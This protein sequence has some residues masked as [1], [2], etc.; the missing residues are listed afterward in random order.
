MQTIRLVLIGVGQLGRRFCRLVEAKE[1]LLRES[2]AL[3]LLLVGVADS[4]GAAWSSEGLDWGEV[5]AIKEQD[6]SVADLPTGRT[7]VTGLTLLQQVEAE[8]LLEASPVNLDQGAEPGLSHIRTAL[9]RGM[10]VVTPNKGPLV[11]AWDELHR[12]AEE[13][14]VA[15]RYDGT[16]AGGLPA[17]ALASRDLRGA[18]I[19]R[20]EAV[21]NL[22]TGYVMDCLADGIPYEEALAMAREEGILEADTSWDL[23]GWDAAAKLVILTRSATGYPATLESVHRIGLASVHPQELKMA[24]SQGYLY[25]MLAR[26]VRTSE[27]LYRLSVAPVPLTPEHPLGRLGRREMGVTFDTDIYGLITATIEEATPLPSAATML[28]DLLKIYRG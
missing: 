7:G 6:Q 23:D 8:L 17:I 27:G 15:L 3:Q 28:R 26:A 21:P 4:R 18:T 2:Y 24:R 13:H 1:Q 9:R 22:V 10:H 16:V 5:A 19:H 20:I 25:R 11:L 14:H 12:L